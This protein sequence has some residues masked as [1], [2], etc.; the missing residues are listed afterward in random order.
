MS[1]AQSVVRVRHCY[2]F[3]T[4]SYRQYIL[5]LMLTGSRSQTLLC[6]RWDRKELFLTAAST[7]R[8]SGD[9]D[10][11]GQVSYVPTTYLLCPLYTT[12]NPRYEPR[13]AAF[14]RP[15]FTPTFIIWVEPSSPAYVELVV[16]DGR[17][18]LVLQLKSRC[19]DP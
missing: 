3:L 19:K 18:S 10:P 8:S 16:L 17:P 5:F 14:T 15:P 11:R 12:P 7:L 2:T 4:I 13:I 9:N 6:L 1:L